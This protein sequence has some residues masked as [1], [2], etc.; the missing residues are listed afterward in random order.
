MG[1]EGD[2]MV[3][4]IDHLD[5]VTHKAGHKLADAMVDRGMSNIERN[6]P[7]ATRHLR[8][9]YHRTPITYSQQA[10]LGYTSVRWSA[11]AWKNEVEG[12]LHANLTASA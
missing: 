11:Y 4:V 10:T 12:H 3:G 2:S 7:V 8:G 6:T 1:Y 9:S 5:N